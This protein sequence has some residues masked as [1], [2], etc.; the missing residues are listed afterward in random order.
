MTEVRCSSSRRSGNERGSG[1][2]SSAGSIA[3]TPPRSPAMNRVPSGYLM[4]Q[5]S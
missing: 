4:R 1:R 2:L 5:V 3:L